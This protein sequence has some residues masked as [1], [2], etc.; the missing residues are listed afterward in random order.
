MFSVFPFSTSHNTLI[1]TISLFLRLGRSL[2]FS[3]MTDHP[4]SAL[5]A[6][7]VGTS[8]AVFSNLFYISQRV[9]PRNPQYYIHSS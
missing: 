3:S 7:G 6:L 9:E 1:A 5:L 4:G 2:N 8:F